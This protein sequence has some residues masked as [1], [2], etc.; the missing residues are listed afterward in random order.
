MELME[1]HVLDLL[2]H[3]EV[4]RVLGSGGRRFDVVLDKST[5]DS[6][7]TGEDTPFDQITEA[8]HHGSLVKLAR[9]R[10]GKKGR[11]SNT[12]DTWSESS[13]SGGKRRYMAV[14]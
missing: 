11:G 2:D 13:W 5:T 9:A 1:N 10:D 12:A 14:P 6:I 7:S 3:R 8:R 4:D